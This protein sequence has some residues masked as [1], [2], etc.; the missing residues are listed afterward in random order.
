MGIERMQDGVYKV[1]ARLRV[2]GKIVQ[3]QCTL[4]GSREEAKALL[5][6]M[7]A[8]LRA[9]DNAGRSL[10]IIE[11]KTFGDLLK[12]FREKREQC[13]ASHLHKI[14]LLERE[15]GKADLRAFPDRFEGWLKVLRTTNSDITSRPRSNACINRL[16]EIVRATFNMGV[17]LGLLP[18]N[19]ISKVRFPRLKELPRDMVLTDQA[20]LRLLNAIDEEAPHLKMLVLYAMQVPCRRSELVNMTKADLDLIHGSIRVKADI[21]KND[22]GCFKPIPPNMLS[23]FR[24]L[25]NETDFLFY[26]KI[27]NKKK[28]TVRYTG[29]GDFK[30]PW[31]V[32]LEKAG[33]TGFHFHDTRHM[34]ATAL[35]DNGTPEQAVM[36]VANWKTNMLRNYYHREPRK[37]L[38]LV[39]F[40]KE[41]ENNVKTSKA[42]AQ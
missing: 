2:N 29:I 8:E 32:C 12:I 4:T 39:R 22:R 7:K 27:E 34:A 30:K 37:A 35:I 19:P 26:K 17:A 42:S 1:K 20:Y 33:L 15:L 3:K 18:G 28:K 11:L 24:N 16:T 21:A 38:E 13:S 10:T 6:K 9:T 31:K 14:R 25:P 23:Y 41:C 36:T 40:S 5:E